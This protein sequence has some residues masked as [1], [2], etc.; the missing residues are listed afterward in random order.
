MWGSARIHFGTT[1]ALL[2]II[3]LPECV[4]NTTPG[5]YA[6]DTQIYAFSASFSE[7]L[8]KLNQDLENIIKYFLKTNYNFI[9][10]KQK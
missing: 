5:M 6:D 10:T 2:Y 9:Q 7:L 1:N 4:R 8:Q 3:D